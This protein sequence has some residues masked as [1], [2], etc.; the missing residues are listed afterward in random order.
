MLYK[1]NTKQ[2]FD[3][4]GFNGLANRS[5][6]RHKHTC[7]CRTVTTTASKAMVK[8]TH[9]SLDV[10]HA[11]VVQL[12]RRAHLEDEPRAH[13]VVDV[14]D[15]GQ[16][17]QE[18]TDEDPALVDDHIVQAF[19]SDPDQEEGQQAAE[20]EQGSHGWL[21]G[22]W[23]CRSATGS[24]FSPWNS[25]FSHCIGHCSPVGATVQ[26]HVDWWK[27]ARAETVLSRNDAGWL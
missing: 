16:W 11:L 18:E 21:L 27:L 20:V 3:W 7:T 10:A 24:N 19:D 4:S 22:R 2:L 17:Q 6:I 23:L 9:L 26:R 8:T 5:A 15:D 1:T 12:G 13:I 14:V 25:S